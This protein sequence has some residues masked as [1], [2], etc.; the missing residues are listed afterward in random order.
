MVVFRDFRL[1]ATGES[2]MQASLIALHQH[3]FFGGI[4]DAFLIAANDQALEARHRGGGTST[5]GGL[6]QGVKI[7]RLLACFAITMM[8]VSSHALAESSKLID[9]LAALSSLVLAC[10]AGRLFQEIRL[11][12]LDKIWIASVRNLITPCSAMNIELLKDQR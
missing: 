8:V 7:Y 1:D 3:H 11:G 5:K 4:F 9:R 10:D 12:P 2:L 6:R